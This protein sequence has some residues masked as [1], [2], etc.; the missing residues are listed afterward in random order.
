M[1]LF[2]GGHSFVGHNEGK[3]SVKTQIAEKYPSRHI[4]QKGV[5]G[6]SFH[7]NGGA[8]LR[9]LVTFAEGKKVTMMYLMVGDNDLFD[10]YGNQR[11]T[12]SDLL[13]SV[14]GLGKEILGRPGTTVTDV[15]F[16]HLFPRVPR[17]PVGNRASLEFD[18]DSP[19]NAEALKYNTYAD[20]YM[21]GKHSTLAFVPGVTF[22]A[23]IHA[24]SHRLCDPNMYGIHRVCGCSSLDIL[25]SDGVHPKS[26]PSEWLEVSDYN[27]MIGPDAMALRSYARVKP[28]DDSTTYRGIMLS[29]VLDAFRCHLHQHCY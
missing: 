18:T 6:L 10:K 26:K 27:T 2:Y 13:M 5:G 3:N 21:D 16:S 24:L 1:S 25:K 29:P 12:A 20:Q 15:V 28:L 7:K 11:M 17:H 22:R 8:D 23:S 19:Y 4:F 9:N 14:V